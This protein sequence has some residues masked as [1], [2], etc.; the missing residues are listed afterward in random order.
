MM[1]EAFDGAGKRP[2]DVEIGGFGGED[3]SKG[4]V[5]GLAVEAGA[6]DACAGKEMRDGLHVVGNM[7]AELARFAR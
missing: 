7:V 1:L 2:E 3:G 6:A 4:C 5:S